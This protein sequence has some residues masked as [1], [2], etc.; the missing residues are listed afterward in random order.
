MNKYVHILHNFIKDED[1]TT[2]INHLDS[3]KSNNKLINRSDGRLCIINSKDVLFTNMVNKY[4]K[5]VRSQ[6]NDEYQ[7]I[8]GYILTIYNEGISMAPH[9]DS[10]E[11]EEF[12]ALFYLNDDYLGGELVV[13]TPEG[14]F[15]HKPKKG[16]LVYFPSWFEHSVLPVTEGTRYFFTISLTKD[17][18]TQ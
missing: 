3:L 6:F 15:K 10:E 16:T 1:C 2:L 13:E 14:K 4:Y 18:A 8:S 17:I 9:I 11:G 12:G 7:N 5:K